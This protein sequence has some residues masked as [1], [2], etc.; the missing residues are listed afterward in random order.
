[1]NAGMIEFRK[2][3]NINNI[4]S[5]TYQFIGKN[6]KQLALAELF[7][8]LPVILLVESVKLVFGFDMYG[9]NSLYGLMVVN[10][11]GAYLIHFPILLLVVSYMNEYVKNG[12]R[13]LEVS[14]TFDVMKKNAAK[15]F[16][17]SITYIIFTFLYSLAF[18]LPGIYY[19]IVQIFKF[20]IGTH[21][22]VDGNYA[23]Q[24]AFKIIKGRWWRV[25]G[26]I[27]VLM[28]NSF[29]FS[30]ITSLPALILGVVY[31]L[32]ATSGSTVDQLNSPAMK[33]AEAF[34][35][36]GNIF[37]IIPMVGIV[38]LYFSLVEESEAVHLKE[39]LAKMLS[40]T[41]QP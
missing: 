2:I 20:F 30:M 22:R 40:P 38:F 10:Y 25:F 23:S 16:I 3:R 17:F 6:F 37:Y 29:L 21:E 32:H 24:R 1:M 36:L 39:R 27:I 8:V 28:L 4:V 14:E 12:Q 19:S 15:M 35:L 11:A 13:P 26:T 5:V 9:S 31:G 7:F 33:I 18:L 41:E 34:S